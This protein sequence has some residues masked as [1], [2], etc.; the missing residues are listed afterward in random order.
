MSVLPPPLA[1]AEIDV[2]SFPFMP[3]HILRLRTSRAW[4]RCKRNP[5]LG[6]YLINLW[7]A[8]WQSKPA[9]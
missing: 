7:T 1:S 8:A 4:M 6:F 2:R 9:G 3:L 5:A